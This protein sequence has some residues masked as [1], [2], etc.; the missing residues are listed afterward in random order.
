MAMGEKLHPKA[1]EVG[2]QK[3]EQRGL[4]LEDQCDG[5]KPLGDEGKIA[6]ELEGVSKALLP[7]E[8]KPGSA[9][10]VFAMPAG[11]REV[12]GTGMDFAELPADFVV[13]PALSEIA[14][15]ELGEG[16][17]VAN[18]GMGWVALKGGAMCC[19]G[20]RAAAEA[21]QGVAAIAG[22]GLMAE[23]FGLLEGSDSFRDQGG[24][25]LTSF[26]GEQED[27]ASIGKFWILVRR[28]G[29]FSFADGLPCLR[30]LLLL[31]LQI[32]EGGVNFGEA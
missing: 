20:F 18:A 19:F 14:Q 23:S 5:G 17:I 26:L 15:A 2:G 3:T 27:A 28:I 24:V 9:G 4:N 32:G 25:A 31:Q 22:G 16:E 11:L 10:K 12:A 7:I 29:G 13:G 30:E 6:E 1:G 8:E 21:E